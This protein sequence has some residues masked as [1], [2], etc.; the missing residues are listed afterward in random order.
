LVSIAK[1]ATSAGSARTQAVA[2]VAGGLAI[3]NTVDAAKDAVGAV[4]DIAKGG[5]LTSLGSVT[6]SVGFSKSKSTSASSDQTVVG[7]SIAGGD[8]NIIARGAGDQS[9]ISITGSSVTARQDLT[10]SAPGAIT[11]KSAQEI[12]TSSSKNKSTGVDIG[13]TLS[14]SG[15]SPATALIMPPA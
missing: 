15:L 11:F 8:V 9:T 4:K 13:V 7:S 3:A 12:D 6:A 5:S 2:A 1:T 14:A 10:L